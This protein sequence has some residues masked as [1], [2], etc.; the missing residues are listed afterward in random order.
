MS[1]RGWTTLVLSLLILTLAGLFY[2]Q[3]SLRVV[4]L[5]LNL[6]LFAFKLQEPAPVPLLLLVTFGVGLLVGAMV[7]VLGRRSPPPETT[8]IGGAG[9]S[10]ADLWT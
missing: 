9:G 8:R 3:N 6:G 2:V 1:W 5:S 4:D 10:G 7:V